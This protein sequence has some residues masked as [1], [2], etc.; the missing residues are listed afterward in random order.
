V[1]RLASQPGV[2]SAWANTLSA[3]RRGAG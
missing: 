2:R 3:Y 1:A